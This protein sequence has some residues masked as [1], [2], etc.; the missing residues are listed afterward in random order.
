MS[1]TRRPIE[2]FDYAKEYIKK[3]PLEEVQIPILDDINKMLWMAAPWR[4]T[5]GVCEPVTVT[6]STA[7]FALVSPP[8]DFLYVSRAYIWDGETAFELTPEPALPSGID[9]KG[10]PNKIAYVSGAT[11]KFRIHPVFG[12]INSSKTY[13]LLVWYKKTS[14]DITKLNMNTVGTAVVDDEWFHVYREGVLWRAYQY[15]DDQRAGNV[16][17]ANNGQIQ[18]SGQRAVFEA[19]VENM[20]KAEPMLTQFM[21]AQGESKKERG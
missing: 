20:R 16:T 19:A 5:M 7:D 12:S 21:R 8:A 6:S 14:P 1:S 11:P 2:A 4:W 13:K 3:M 10:V 17:V 15:G 9:T 18:Y